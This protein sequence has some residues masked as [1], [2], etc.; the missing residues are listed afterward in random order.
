MNPIEHAPITI[1]V[2]DSGLGGLSV[3]GAIRRALPSARI[4]YY[5]D[6]AY[7]PYGPRTDAEIIER[8]EHCC[9]VLLAQ[10]LHALVVAC[11][12]ATATA[13]DALRAW[14]PVPVIGVEPGLKPAAAQ[15][16]SGRIGVL[17]TASTLRSARYR[18]LVQ[19]VSAQFPGA[20]FVEAVGHGWV[21]QVEQ[22]D[23]DSAQTRRLVADALTPLISASVDTLVLGCTH[24][25]FLAAQ[26]AAITHELPMI[27]TGDA[28]ARECLRRLELS[29]EASAS[30]AT[31]IEGAFEWLS[32]DGDRTRHALASQ[33]MAVTG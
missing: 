6:T 29:A 2:F 11:N 1:G 8:T 30:P 25:P 26:I 31:A 15:S 33:L 32:S 14:A 17:A 12:T 21:E 18:D 7:A 19:R 28:V 22:G 24:Y 20:Q 4:R 23:L 5:A 16:T 27:E 13:I 10:P 9:S 3:A